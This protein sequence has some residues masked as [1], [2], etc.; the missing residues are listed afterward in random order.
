M[1]RLAA[2]L[3]VAL[4]SGCMGASQD[5]PPADAGGPT[6]AQSAPSA[7]V[8]ADTDEAAAPTNDTVEPPS[9]TTRADA[10]VEPPAAAPAASIEVHPGQRAWTTVDSRSIGFTVGFL[11]RSPDNSTWYIATVAHAMHLGPLDVPLGNPVQV[12]QGTIGHFVFDGWADGRAL[13][14][15]FAL[16][17]LNDEG[18]R[19]AEAA[20][21]EWGGPVGLADP[22]LTLPGTHVF[23]YGATREGPMQGRFLDE[24]GGIAMAR[25][26]RPVEPGDS[27]SPIMTWDGHAL[28]LAMAHT[29]L[30]VAEDQG[31]RIMFITS[32]DRSL[33]RAAAAGFDLELVTAAYE[34]PPLPV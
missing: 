21:P 28:G 16:I 9:N 14:D 2:V 34:S 10:P 11:L 17:Q 30:P 3:L 25:F 33:E 29:S 20:V 4:L 18:R 12:A 1:R 22:D 26:E 8:E 13:E 32:L 5:E 7:Q 24:D 27:G 15:D 23:S 19:G 31:H 6:T